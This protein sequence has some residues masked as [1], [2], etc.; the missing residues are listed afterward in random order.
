MDLFLTVLGWV[1]WGALVVL[2]YLVVPGNIWKGFDP[3]W[4]ELGYDGQL[5]ANFVYWAFLI[6]GSLVFSLGDTSRLHILWTFPVF[7]ASA[8]WI[9]EISESNDRN[10]ITRITNKLRRDANDGTARRFVFL[11]AGLAAAFLSA[12]L[13]KRYLAPTL[14]ELTKNS[15]VQAVGFGVPA[16]VV[17]VAL[18]SFLKIV[19]DHI[20]AP[21]CARCRELL[22]AL[23]AAKPLGESIDRLVMAGL[24][25]TVGYVCRG[26]GA[27][28]CQRCM[29]QG[30]GASC[31]A[32]GGRVEYF[33][34]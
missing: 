33:V 20:R 26:C 29:E 1:A 15:V 11:W 4:A 13:L 16:V 9:Q 28:H 14:G 5:H 30:G 27:Y 8:W 21:K 6:P 23:D 34:K 25:R 31:R 2:T 22:S 10:W 18:G 17:L 12:V 32:C 7:G 24:G 3:K 19:R